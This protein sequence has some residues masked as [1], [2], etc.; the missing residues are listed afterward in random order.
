MAY[1]ETIGSSAPA[2]LVLTFDSAPW[3]PLAPSKRY[4]G[5]AGWEHDMAWHDMA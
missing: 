4:R 2:I 3:V 5:I 1:M